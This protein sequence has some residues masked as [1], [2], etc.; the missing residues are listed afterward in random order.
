MKYQG[1]QIQIYII[2]NSGGYVKIGLSE[3]VE[4][5]LSSLSG[6]NGGGHKIIR[7]WVSPKTYLYTM[8]RIMHQHFHEYRISGTEWFEDISFDEVVLYAEELFNSSEFKR[9]EQI[10]KDAYERKQRK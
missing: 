7:S 2:E 1:K 4:Q 6:S 8:E 5:R 9:C 3:N 10:R